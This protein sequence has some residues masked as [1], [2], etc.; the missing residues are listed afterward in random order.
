VRDGVK[1]AEVGPEVLDGE[2]LP[3]EVHGEL[4]PPMASHGPNDV[5]RAWRV[6][7]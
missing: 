5:A 3:V 6:A 7:P 1:Q 4:L 2:L